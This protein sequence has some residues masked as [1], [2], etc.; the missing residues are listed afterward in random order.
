MKI[1]RN[2]CTV[3]HIFPWLFT[4]LIST[5]GSI[6]ASFNHPS[7]ITNWSCC[8]LEE[9][10]PKVVLC[11]MSPPFPKVSKSFQKCSKSNKHSSCSSTAQK[12]PNILFGVCA[13]SVRVVFTPSQARAHAG[14]R[15]SSDVAHFSFQT[16]KISKTEAS[17]HG[18]KTF[19][20]DAGEAPPVEWIHW[21]WDW[22]LSIIQWAHYVYVFLLM[23][24]IVCLCLNSGESSTE[25]CA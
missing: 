16:G 15:S 14:C 23:E 18:P 1:F 24:S 3:F 8:S 9:T 13:P 21:K 25:I 17:N 5:E 7:P 20:N 11:A 19:G 12:Y 6:Q 4:K 2:S 10:S 22:N